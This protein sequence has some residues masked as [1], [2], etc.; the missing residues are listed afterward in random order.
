MVLEG[1]ARAGAEEGDRD[2]VTVLHAP[3]D[4]DESIVA[5]A[6]TA[7]EPVTLVSADRAL[8]E[9]CRTLGAGVV[10]PGWLLAR[11]GG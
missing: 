7:A 8:G 1:Q 2:G 11:L 5:V 3:G 9:R 4:G 10:G 6:A